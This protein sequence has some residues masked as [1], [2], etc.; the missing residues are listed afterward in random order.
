M[1]QTRLI[2]LKP[3]NLTTPG[4]NQIGY[5]YAHGKINT[6]SVNGQ[7]LLSSITYEPH[8]PVSGWTWPSGLPHV[9]AHGLDGEVHR[10]KSTF[11]NSPCFQAV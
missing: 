8:G 3:G 7:A 1:G 4:G 2:P 10:F 6:I 5:T 9:R 11:R